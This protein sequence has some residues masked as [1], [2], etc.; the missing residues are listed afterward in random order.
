MSTNEQ[1]KKKREAF[2]W[3]KFFPCHWIDILM[4]TDNKAGKR[5]KQAITRLIDNNAPEGTEE[6]KMISE[7][8]MFSQ[9][10][11]ARVMNRWKIPLPKDKS[12]V[13]AFAEDNGLD[14]DDAL[15]WAQINLK[16]RHGKDKD[17]EPIMNWQKHCAGYCEAKRNKRQ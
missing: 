13:I 7:S 16:E 10:Q 5:F 1:P 12:E 9:R 3:Y 6:H 15:E 14:V 8:V 11:R 17:G 2:V 4:M